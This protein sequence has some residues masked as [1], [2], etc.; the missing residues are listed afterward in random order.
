[1]QKKYLGLTCLALVLAACSDSSTAP[2]QPSSGTPSSIVAGP[3]KVMRL[4]GSLPAGGV[5]GQATGILYH[6]G[7]ILAQTKVAAIYWANSTVYAGGPAPGTAGT[8]AQDG[9]LVGHFLR[10]LGGS[11][12]FNIN[13]TYT[14]AV[15]GGH[16]VQNSVTYTQYW[17]DNTSVPPANGSTVSNATIQ[18]EIIKGFNNGSL[19]YD[20][21]TIYAVFTTGNTNLGGGFGS[22][23]CAYHGNFQFNGQLVI[24]AAQPYVGV[25]L[26]GCSGGTASPNG[27][28]AADAVINVLAHEIEESTTDYAL[29]AW[30]D[31]AGAENA[32]KCA[33]NFG[34]TYNNGTGVANMNLGGKDFLI[35]Q[36]W[37]NSGNGGC[38]LTFGGVSNKPPVASYT[39]SCTGL[40]CSFDGT[41]SADSDGTIVSYAWKV[42]ANTISTAS[43]FSKTFPVAKTFALTLTVTDN[44]GASTSLTKTITV[45]GA[46][47]VPPIASF[48]SSCTAAHT[49]TF[50]ST[51]TD[52][53]GTVVGWKWTNPSGTSTVSTAASFSKTF[54]SARTVTFMLTVTDNGGATGAV[55]Q[56]VVVP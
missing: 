54:P 45:G 35:Q 19:I 55:T 49:C 7:P 31:A 39:S 24:Y 48:T 42:G 8:G 4:R 41:A 25:Q 40:T 15:G 10:N 6:G 12:Y 38:L 18:A 37:V 20:P 51:S 9:S 14:D 53:D 21:Q 50:T 11:G 3:T 26:G 43:S 13:T 28:A 5:S 34:S 2:T 16:T 30:Y 52:P 29:N 33:W 44:N 32:D 36:N 56:S 22:Q 23:Y 46:T 47:N 17:A 27:D 1:M